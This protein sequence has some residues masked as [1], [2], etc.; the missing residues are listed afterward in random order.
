MSSSQTLDQT[1]SQVY[2]DTSIRD[3]Y[4]ANHII[5]AFYKDNK[6]SLIVSLDLFFQDRLSVSIF[7]KMRIYIK[8][9]KTNFSF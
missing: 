3:S 7:F 1:F 5:Y 4:V 2:I 6:I 9:K 8:I